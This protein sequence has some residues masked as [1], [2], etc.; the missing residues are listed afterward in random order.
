MNSYDIAAQQAVAE[1]RPFTSLL[2]RQGFPKVMWMNVYRSGWFHRAGKPSTID[3]HAGDFYE[4]REQAMA[5]IDPPSHYITTVPF[6]YVDPEDV[7]AN[8]ADSTPVPL[9]VTRAQ[10]DRQARVQELLRRRELATA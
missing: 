10:V 8:A 2:P 1:G 5:D 6:T 7:H 9:A 4:T 3:R